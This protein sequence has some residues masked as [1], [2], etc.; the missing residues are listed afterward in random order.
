MSIL[1]STVGLPRAF[2]H[3]DDPKR[4]LRSAS[5]HAQPLLA[6]SDLETE[7]CQHE[8]LQLKLKKLLLQLL[9]TRKLT[10]C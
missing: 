2:P 8:T 4:K 6:A 5:G 1:A 10:R 7:F 3:A 9:A